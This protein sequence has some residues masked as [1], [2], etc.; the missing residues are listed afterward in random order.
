MLLLFIGCRLGQL[1]RSLSWWSTLRPVLLGP[2]RG[3]AARPLL[4]GTVPSGIRGA[5]AAGVLGRRSSEFGA[6][7][8][9]R[10][11]KGEGGH[12]ETDG[13]EDMS[14]KKTWRNET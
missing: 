12:H 8:S 7:R 6:R 2:R 13:T 14:S 11:V 10:G 9:K 1:F 5:P 4:L 3:T